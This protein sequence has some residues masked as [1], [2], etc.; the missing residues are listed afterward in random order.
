M[1][2]VQFL[3]DEAGTKTAV[4]ID[5][6]LYGDLLEDFFDIVIARE[7]KDEEDIPWEVVEKEIEEDLAKEGT[8]GVV[9][10]RDEVLSADT[11]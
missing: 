1:K 2:G 4:L 5:L 11:A 8:G 7:R 3:V 9:S 6:A 10:R